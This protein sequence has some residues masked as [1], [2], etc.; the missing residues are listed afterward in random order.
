MGPILYAIFVAPLYDISKLSN[1]A[2]DNF[3]LTQ[4]KNK[5]TCVSNMETK[6]KVII[7][8]F[9]GSGLKVSE[10]KTEICMFHRID[11][12]QVEIDVCNIHV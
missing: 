7:K 10:A 11:T 3:A 1:F 6:L 5:I 8:W 12:T 2:D 4:N 9:K